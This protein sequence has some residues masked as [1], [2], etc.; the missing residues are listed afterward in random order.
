M[1]GYI[2]CFNTSESPNIIKA[3]HTHQDVKKRLR[4]YLG[5]SRP[6]S[7][8][9][10]VQVDDSI[11]AEKM[12][13]LLMRQCVS[14]KQRHDLGNEWFETNG[15]FNFQERATHLQ[16]IA[17]IVKKASSV[18]TNLS[19]SSKVS[20][21]EPDEIFPEMEE[22]ALSLRGLEEYFKKFDDYVAQYAPQCGDALS[23]LKRYESSPFCPYIC[24]YLPF[25]ETK[26][27]QVTANRYVNFISH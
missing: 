2:Y 23:L 15:D 11:E 12:M 1:K 22:V 3:G 16:S 8:I 19:V 27:V 25:S 10:E 4:G 6:R 20:S 13:L 7:I 26:R 9:F 17:K 18:Q 5:P 21:K 24:E 14:L